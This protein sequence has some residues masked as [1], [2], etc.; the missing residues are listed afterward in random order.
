[1]SHVVFTF[2]YTLV[3]RYRLYYIGLRFEYTV[4]AEAIRRLSYSFWLL[5]LHRASSERI[6]SLRKPHGTEILRALRG[7][8]TI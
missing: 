5:P 8:R 4:F 1:M 6:S 2:V 3:M 7:P